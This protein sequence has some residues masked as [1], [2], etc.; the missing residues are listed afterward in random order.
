MDIYEYIASNPASQQSA[1]NLCVNNGI[2]PID[3]TDLANC[4]GEYV[5]ANGELGLKKVMAIHPDK[6]LL[7]N[8]YS[9]PP[10]ETTQ[11]MANI[12]YANAIGGDVDNTT[13]NSNA[14]HTN[15]ALQTNIIIIAA[16]I[17]IGF[18]IISKN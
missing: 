1:I 2:E 10:S 17:V 11:R 8:Y 7:I 18:A 6:D 5:N 13:S 16:A 15:I 9:V 12:K 3:E 14:T 4:L